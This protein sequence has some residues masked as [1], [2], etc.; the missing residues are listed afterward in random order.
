M[1]KTSRRPVLAAA[2]ALMGAGGL[3]APGPALAQA[4]PNR[5]ITVI[6]PFAAG[7]PTDVINRLV[8]EG[9]SKELGQPVVV[10]NVT[11]A[12]GTIAAGRVANARPDGYTILAHHIGHATSATL[13]RNLP[14]NV[15]TSFAPLGLVSDAAMTIV[16]RPDFPANDLAG[17]M[18]EIKRQGDKLNLAHAGVGGANHL[19]GVLMQYAAKTNLT[20]VAFRGSAPVLTEMMAGRI[21]VFCDQATNTTPFIRDNRIR[22]Y[23]VTLDRRVEGLNLPTTAEAGEPSIAMSTWHGLYAPA[24]TPEP[25]VERLSV[26][27]RAAL[28]EERL[29]A[30]FAELVTE[31]ASQE[32]ATPAAHRRHLAAEVA[33]WRPIIQAAGVYAD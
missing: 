20:T 10:E 12:G 7:G 24:G 22:S 11:G 6:V 23:A 27:I 31:V 33:R 32:Q 16:A 18:A 5:A 25:V 30:R 1:S 28:R 26:A 2:L 8:A 21:D 4:F 17:L 3:A 15:E 19:C 13:Y 9:M 29:R 14:Y